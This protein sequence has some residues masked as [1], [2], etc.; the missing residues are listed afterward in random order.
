[1]TPHVFVRHPPLPQMRGTC[2]GRLDAMPE[3]QAFVD[4]AAALAAQLPDRPLACSPSLRCRRLAEA[5]HA[6]ALARG[7]SPRPPRVDARLRELDFG[8][9][10]GQRWDAIPRAALEAWSADVAGFAPPG[11]ES[12]DSLV[13]RVRE[14][15]GALDG[16][17]VVVTHAGVIR[18]AHRL[19][20]W[21]VDAAAALAV[22]HLQPIA[23]ALPVRR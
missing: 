7:R 20:G 21:T 11:G 17:H 8:D 6:D 5:L 18:A 2:Y 16:P 3:A 4:A 14:A 13:D 9:W 12:F 1:M 22:P 19:A 23:L 15:L 10:E